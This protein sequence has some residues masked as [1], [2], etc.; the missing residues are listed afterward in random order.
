MQEYTIVI[1][2]GSARPFTLHT[3]NSFE[4]CYSSLLQ[5]IH[6]NTVKR[7]YYVQNDFYKNTYTP[8]LPNITKYTIKVRKVS[9]WEIYS[10][11]KHKIEKTNN[12]INIFN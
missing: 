8:F 11:E 9:E 3:Y 12:I 6:T 4:I 10:K 2:H 1:Q 5:M 7:E